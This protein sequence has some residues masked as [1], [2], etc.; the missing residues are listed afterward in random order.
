[1]SRRRVIAALERAAGSIT[2][3]IDQIVLRQA[4]A[5]SPAANEVVV[6][7]RACCVNY[8]DLLSLAN[9]YQHKAAFPYTPGL[10]WAGVV[11]ELGPDVHSWSVGDRVTGG[12]PP[13]GGGLASEVV[14]PSELLQPMPASQSF[15]H[16]AAFWTGYAT[17]YHCLFERGKLQPGEWVLVNGA[18]GGM[19][20]AAAQLAH[21]AGAKVIALGGS[22]AKL[23][24]VAAHV[25]VAARVNYEATPAFAAEVKRLTGGGG[26][27][28]V[29]DSV[30][31]AVGRESL[32]A[33]GSIA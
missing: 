16:G 21:R 19:G 14:V 13:G 33:T 22:D 6:S 26:V 30:G 18:T 7:V 10:E 24:A 29:F 9:Q 15:A 1:M 8:P 5:S 28:M 17:A 12:G 11:Q 4:P 2:E 23:A 31:G 25:P 3:G 27:D 20:L 32:R